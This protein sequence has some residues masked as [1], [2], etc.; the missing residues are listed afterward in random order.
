MIVRSLNSQAVNVHLNLV[1]TAPELSTAAL[2][3][4]GIIPHRRRRQ[5]YR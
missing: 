2:R 4:E 3:F 5:Y 1:A